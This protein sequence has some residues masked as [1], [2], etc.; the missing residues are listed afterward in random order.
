MDNI[1]DHDLIIAENGVC[2]HCHNYDAAY[3]KL[4]S[5]EATT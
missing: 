3:G 2:N 4:P 5:E 1:N